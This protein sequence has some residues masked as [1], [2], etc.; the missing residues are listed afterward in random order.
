[1]QETGADVLVLS[2]ENY[3]GGVPAQDPDGPH[4]LTYYT[5]A[6]DELGVDYDIYDVETRRT[7]RSPD[8]LGVLSHYDAVIWYTGDDYLTRLPEPVP[9]APARARFARRGA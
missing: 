4:Y 7:T 1:M 3:T 8:P 6:L 9:A 5:D 2:D